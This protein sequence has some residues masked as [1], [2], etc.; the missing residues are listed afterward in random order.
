MDK[1]EHGW[2]VHRNWKNVNFSDKTQVVI[3]QNK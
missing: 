2:T 3:D 1:L